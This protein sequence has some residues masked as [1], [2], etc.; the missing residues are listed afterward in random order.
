VPID[1][2][3][4]FT[5]FP[6]LDACGA[7]ESLAVVNASGA[8]EPCA[9]VIAFDASS[10]LAV[11]AAFAALD[12]LAAFTTF[13]AFEPRVLVDRLG[14]SSELTVFPPPPTVD[15]FTVVAACDIF[16]ISVALATFRPVRATCV[17]ERAGPLDRFGASRAVATVALTDA[18]GTLEV[19]EAARALSAC[20]RVIAVDAIESAPCEA[21]ASSGVPDTSGPDAAAVLAAT[22]P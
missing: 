21:L 18:L 12:G 9:D 15:A 13:D 3:G 22:R 10:S 4:P 1:A 20:A 16:D 8:L 11:I 17:L 7:L 14:T 19:F 6:T 2:P 5:R